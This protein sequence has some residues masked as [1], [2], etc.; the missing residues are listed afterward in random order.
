VKDI[1]KTAGEHPWTGVAHQF[2]DRD[3]AALNLSEAET[4]LYAPRLQKL[5][6]EAYADGRESAHHEIVCELEG[7]GLSSR[8]WPDR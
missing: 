8:K 4:A 6:E 1:P 2:L 3:L 7:G 5:L